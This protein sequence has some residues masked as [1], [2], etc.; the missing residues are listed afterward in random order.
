MPESGPRVLVVDDEPAIRR[1]LRVSLEAHGYTLHEAATGE[2]ALQVVPACRPD[3]IILDMGLPG[4]DGTEVVRCLREWA[5]TPILILSV[6]GDESAKIA[7]L[8]AGAD[9]YLTKP[10][11]PGELLARL[12][13]MLRRAGRQES[14]PVFVS[15]PLMVD[16]SS[17]MVTLGEDE[18]RLTPT[19][20][21]L[22]KALVTHA[23]KILTHRQL[24]REVWGGSQYEDTQHL[25]RVNVSNL[26]RKI[27]T[28]PSRPQYIVTEP[29]VGYRLLQPS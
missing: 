20:Y 7:A 14:G 2:E 11:G 8:D 15:G 4:M 18:V 3:L 24:I 17:R 21:S 29:G 5:Q 13:A 23:G 6:Q 16:L 25:L 19:E 22:L 9:D 27:E 26:R 12:R 28:D 1:F 10:F